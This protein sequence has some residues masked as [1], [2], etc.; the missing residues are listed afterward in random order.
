M[1]A[2]AG[3]VVLAGV[4]CLLAAPALA[5]SI[6]GDRGEGAPAVW[7]TTGIAQP[8]YVHALSR[9]ALTA[10]NLTLPRGETQ[11]GAALSNSELRIVPEVLFAPGTGRGCAVLRSVR[12]VWRVAAIRVDI[13]RDYAPD[14]CAYRVILAHENQHVGF[15]RQAY[16]GSLEEMRRTLSIAARDFATVDVLAS[17]PQAAANEVALRFQGRLKPVVMAYDRELR[18]LNAS[19]DT[20]GNYAAVHRL[21][22]DW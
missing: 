22:R 4:A 3:R 9:A 17:T 20:P 21:C 11:L 10:A 13:A 16:E 18:R 12:V 14:S 8:V 19:I 5:C 6:P 7:L 1:R 2:M 15:T